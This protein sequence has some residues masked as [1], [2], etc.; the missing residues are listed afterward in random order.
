MKRIISIS[1]LAGA[2]A[3][4]PSCSKESVF[5]GGENA[6]TGSL[7]TKSLLLEFQNEEKLV[8]SVDLNV[9][10]FQVEIV[11]DGSDTPLYSYKYAELPEVVTLPVGSYRAVASYGD[12][13]N[14]A[15]EAPYYTGDTE[16]E[17]RAGEITDDL[18]TITCRFSNVR[19]TV[20]F[21]PV[22]TSLMGPDSKVEVNVGTSTLTFTKNDE[23][24]SGYFPY[25]DG[26]M[27]MAA[28][29]TGTVEGTE[30]V[31]TKLYQD[32]APGNHYRLTFRM[33]TISEDDFGD[34][35]G[36]LLVD[37][38]VS[39]DDL[40]FD[41]DVEDSYLPDDRDPSIDEPETPGPGPDEPVTPGPDEKEAPSIEGQ[42]GVQLGVP[43]NVNNLSECKIDIVSHAAGGITEFK[44]DIISEALTEEE[45]SSMGLGTHL[46]LVNPGDMGIGLS[47]LGLPVNVGGQTEVTFDITTFLMILP[48]GEHQFK[49]TVTDANGTTEKTLILTK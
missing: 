22:L 39:V 32:V 3:L 48:E 19:V 33:H 14:A 7:S 28:T 24:R 41:F 43:N 27:T 12:N 18:G 2:V 47:G 46:D 38:T 8:R 25:L 20:L 35:N 16:F 1:L 6:L 13:D 42:N 44:V 5:G 4:L 49:M 21:D 9:G 15:F 37:A 26:S 45:M 10:D 31:E 11:A 29:F 30:T 36:N 17:I 23:T 40:N 34:I